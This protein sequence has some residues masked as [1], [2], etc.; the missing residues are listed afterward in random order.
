MNLRLSKNFLF[1]KEFIV[2]FFIEILISKFLLNFI[3][4]IYR[5]LLQLVL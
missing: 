3:R 5:N 4:K 2:N 1:I